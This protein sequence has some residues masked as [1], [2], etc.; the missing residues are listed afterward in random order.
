M[1]K[2]TNLCKKKQGVYLLWLQ[3]YCNSPVTKYYTDFNKVSLVCSN[4]HKSKWHYLYLKISVFLKSIHFQNKGP[5]LVKNTMI[6]DLFLG[7]N[8][9]LHSAESHRGLLSVARFLP[10]PSVS[11]SRITG[12]L[13]WQE[14]FLSHRKKS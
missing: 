8:G 4:W 7:G 3:K 2:A 9:D 10:L 6:P 11:G 14:Y 5:P 12:T 1:A 13:R